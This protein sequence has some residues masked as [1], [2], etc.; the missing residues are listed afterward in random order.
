MKYKLPLEQLNEILKY[1]VNRPYIEV[2]E[3]V[4]YLKRAEKDE[5][6]GD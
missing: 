6:D 3:L 5:E 1:L 4:E 2:V